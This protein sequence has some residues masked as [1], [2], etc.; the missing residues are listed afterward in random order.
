[1]DL[2]SIKPGLLTTRA[3]MHEVFGG[4]SQGGIILPK[5]S[6]NILIY[7][8]HDSGKKYGYEDG[9]LEEEDEFGPIFEYTGQGTR[10]AQTFLG[11]R[12]SRNAAVLYHADAGKSLRVFMAAGRV[13][14]SK[15][16]AKQQRYVGE[17]ALDARLPYTVREALDE[18]RKPRL[19]IVFRLRPK[20]AFERLTQDVI[21]R[22]DVTA[23]Q[24][25]SAQIVTTKLVEPKRSKRSESRRA[26]QPSLIAEL[27]QGAVR[28]QYLTELTKR[29]HDVAAFQIK[30][31]GT[32]TILTTDLYDATEHELYAIRGAST[33]EEIRMA[34]GQLK[35][36]ARHI[37]PRNP[38]LTTVL[39]EKP[40]DDLVNL[41]HS[42]GIDLVLDN[43]H[44]Y[45]RYAA[46]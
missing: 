15:S 24:R 14:G 25:V 19:I 41:L 28:E 11:Q 32:T 40:Q 44:G 5:N 2:A 3:A 18:E 39:P 36:F 16:A 46:E 23:P 34:I 35:D 26:A 4:G 10:G 33:R 9:W 1:M 31:S 38:K 13:A 22:A 6:P 8:D 17:F 20:G 37:R 27:R 12:G 30:I 43:T 7:T 29:G 21:T 42:E 45:T